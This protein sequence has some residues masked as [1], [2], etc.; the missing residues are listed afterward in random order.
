MTEL[1]IIVL[2]RPSSENWK[3]ERSL[4]AVL[5]ALE[6][7]KDETHQK[8]AQFYPPYLRAVQK[9]AA[10]VDL[11]SALS[12]T[13]DQRAELE[14]RVAQLSALAQLGV[15]VEIVGHEFERLDYEVS[16]NLRRLPEEIRKSDA[17]QLAMSAHQ[18]L[19]NRLRFLAPLKLSGPQLRDIIKGEQIYSRRRVLRR[20]HRR[21]QS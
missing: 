17:F 10:D 20:C 2:R 18:A 16:R 11:D 6:R 19:V 12:W 3:T 21:W 15:T 7:L 8:V 4:Q 14:E 13:G 1:S 5:A 9:L